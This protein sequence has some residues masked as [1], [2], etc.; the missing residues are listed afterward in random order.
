[1]SD[2]ID[3][4]ERARARLALRHLLDSAAGPRLETRAR[5]LSV[6]G[7]ARVLI[8][9]VGLVVALVGVAVVG[10]A[11]LVSNGPIDLDRF[12]P[13]LLA[14]L[15]ERLGRSYEV[16]L[17]STSLTHASAGFGLGLGFTDIRISDAQG[18]TL[19][20]A[21]SGRIGLDFFSLLTFDVSV[22]RL[23]LDGLVL[24]LHVAKSGEIA[25]AA[26][27]NR[28]AAS[29]A[30]APP[31]NAGGAALAA[32]GAIVNGLADALAGG[33]RPIDHIT[34]VNGHLNVD[35]EALG[36]T[37]AY[38]NFAISYDRSAAAAAVEISARG[39]SG[40]WR[41]A[42]R[43]SAGAGRKLTLEGRDLALH[44]ILMVSAARPPF[45]TDMPLSFSLNAEVDADGALRSAEAAF[46]AGAGYFKLDNPDHK[47]LLI[48][49]A[50]GELH[51]DPA[52]RR[53]D[54]RRLE[55]LTG[56]SH[57][58]FDGALLPPEGGQGPWRLHFESGDSVYG[59]ERP[60]QAPVKIDRAVA[61]GRFFPVEGRL[62]LDRLTVHGPK[63]QGELSLE[64]TPQDGGAAL[65]LTMRVGPTSLVDGLRL[66]PSF[67]NPD[68]RAWC[69]DNIR[70]GEVVSGSLKVDFD[71]KT[72]RDTMEKRALPAE[73][74]QGEFS[75][76]GGAV[77]LLP[78]LP[79]LTGL[80]GAGVVTGKT[81]DA[82]AKSG[83]MELSAGRRLYAADVY[84][85]IPKTDPAPIVAGEA[86]GHVTGGADALADLMS[87]DAMKSY[88]GMTLDPA[89]VKGQ[90]QG[91]L[92]IALALGKT[93]K[94]EDQKFHVEGALMNLTVDGYV[95][96]EKFEQGALDLLADAGAFKL[97]G[98][99]LFNTIPAK[100]E[101]SKAPA[102]DGQV[103]LT[104]A[105]DNATRA[106]LG[107]TP[108]VTLNGPITAKL[109][110]QFNRPGADAD[111][112]L[113]KA[114]IDG[115]DGAL[116]K[117]VGKPGKAT[118]AL[119]TSPDGMAISGLSVDAGALSAR[120][121]ADFGADG[122][123]QDLKLTQVRFAPSDDMKLDIQG[124]TPIKATLRGA[125]LDARGFVKSLLG[126]D[127]AAP[128]ARDLDLD[129]KLDS[130]RGGNDQRV[131]QLDL[132]MTRRNGALRGLKLRGRLGQGALSVVKDDGGLMVMN[133]D[134][135]G[136]A[137]K[138]LDIYTRIEGGALHM[139][140]KDEADGSHGVA[141]LKHFTLRNETALRKMS[142]AAPPAAS[143]RKGAVANSADVDSAQFDR[144]SATFVRSGGR[145]DV[146]DLLVYNASQGV[147]A[148]GYIDFARDKVEL[149]GTFVPIYPVNNL[150]TGIPIV[151]MLLGGGQH[152]GM[153]A[154][155][156]RITG[157]ASAPT[158]T[159]NP[160]SGVTPGI[161]RKL[162]GVIDGTQLPTSPPPDDETGK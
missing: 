73:A 74:L 153:F 16:S 9:V 41:I 133:A 24:N 95:G 56:A 91:Q 132:Q 96:N 69:V 97:T 76:R 106:R 62:D 66:W 112:D 33:E 45:E 7:L 103:A 130:A 116:L 77:N 94:P 28:D 101:V 58:R 145:T 75:V 134:D 72:L 126:R 84:F 31:A 155:N 37:L 13:T 4:A 30:Y 121:S 2:R 27:G 88:A 38:E 148:N 67:I 48:D 29:L 68:V 152:E 143:N 59:P 21:P 110:T 105:L 63:L 104:L 81:F 5:K 127:P 25:I 158:L 23:E 78:G 71:A 100:V 154:V 139:T 8:G 159:V 26:A 123:L 156:F 141:T 162:F 22:R 90:G 10:F 57:Y 128:S 120:G 85:R 60:G 125:S 11:Y 65:K 15:Q 140:L 70:A 107:L 138:F 82:H 92:A 113:A 43:A 44:D 142:S 87:R 99:G 55:M 32:P 144:L 129:A 61:D 161:L 114:E 3:G 117:A 39:P 80:D 157:Q 6:S 115:V 79:P 89:K 98:Q 36:R 42:A 124:G 108:G 137:A 50:S 53:F 111:V 14:A 54:A 1:M 51:W 109:K 151:G 47:P 86:G 147:S 19:I 83:Q 149:A 135:G 136:A 12:K 46:A 119:K 18:R 131:S 52:A 122:A 20:A 35:N 93:A 102:E 118:F 34:I 64:A 40:P 146:S 150:V 160:L 49:E 17:G